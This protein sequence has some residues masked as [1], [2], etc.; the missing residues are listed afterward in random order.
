MQVKRTATYA[1]VLVFLGFSVAKIDDH[2]RQ[3]MWGW[4]WTLEP[5]PDFPQNKPIEQLRQCPHGDLV[6]PPWH[7]YVLWDNQGGYWWRSFLQERGR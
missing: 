5:K 4:V 7:V 2:V 3:S 1:F 6:L